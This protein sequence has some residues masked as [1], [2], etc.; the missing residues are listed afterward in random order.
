VLVPWTPLAPSQRERR[1]QQLGGTLA[2]ISAVVLAIAATRADPFGSIQA[3]LAVLLAAG[4][5]FA[6]R[7][8]RSPTFEVAI[9]ADGQLLLRLTAAPDRALPARCG[10]AA[11]WLISVRSD[12]MWVPIWPDSVPS[13]AFRRLWVHIR[14]SSGGARTDP[15]GSSHQPQ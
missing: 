12:T 6:W 4:A 10:F 1:L 15:S 8:R 7:A 5:V 3:V 11:P 13:N 9:D 2:L 14:W